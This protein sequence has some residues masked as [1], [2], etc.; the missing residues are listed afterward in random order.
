MVQRLSA[1]YPLTSQVRQPET[2]VVT[3][4]LRAGPGG[5]LTPTTYGQSSPATSAPS[6]ESLAQP[7][8]SKGDNHES[9]W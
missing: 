4:L 3:A 5:R 2:I 8:K 1:D 9:R 7:R 6:V